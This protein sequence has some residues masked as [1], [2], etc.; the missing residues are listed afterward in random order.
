MSTVFARWHIPGLLLRQEVRQNTFVFANL[1]AAIEGVRQHKTIHFAGKDAAKA[2]D[3]GSTNQ[4]RHTRVDTSGDSLWT[5]LERH[6]AEEE[7]MLKMKEDEGVANKICSSDADNDDFLSGVQDFSKP[8]TPS[9]THKEP[10]AFLKPYPSTLVGKIDEV[11]SES[12]SVDIDD[13]L[14]NVHSS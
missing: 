10:D 14:Q 2:C 13:D 4:K 11:D 6:L 3:K 12:D 5:D 9:E 1:K 8:S 7:L